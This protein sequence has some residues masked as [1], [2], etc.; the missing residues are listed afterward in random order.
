MAPN[1]EHNMKRPPVVVIVG[2][3]D[4]GKTTL[5]DYIRKTS[6]ATREAG[7]I[8]QSIGAYEI[9]HHSERI[10]FIDTP[11]HEA[12]SNMRRRGVAVADIAI[13][14]V[15]VDD[16]VQ[17]Q[18]REAIK[19]IRES[20]T[21]CI[22][23]FNKIDKSGVNVERVQ[24][25]LATEGIL[26]EGRGGNVSFQMISA[27]TGEGIPELL[28][29]IALVADVQG[30]TYDSSLPGE[31]VIIESKLDGKSGVTA[32]AVIKNGTL[33]VGD[34]ISAGKA[35]GKVRG[36]ENF[37]GERVTEVAPSTPV[38]VFGF[39]DLPGVGELLLSGSRANSSGAAAG[40]PKAI[41]PRLPANAPK[42]QGA[43]NIIL[44]ADVAGSLETLGEIMKKIKVP[45]N[46]KIKI[47]DS[48]VGDI[49]DGDAKLAVSTGSII[50]GFNVKITKAGANVAGAHRVAVITSDIIYDLEKKIMGQFIG[51]DASAV[52]GDLEILAV[53]GKKGVREQI[54]GGKIIAGSISNG[55]A[56]ELMRNGVSLGKGKITNLQT[57]KKNAVRVETG[58]EA[59][60]LVEADAEIKIGDHILSR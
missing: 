16:G 60:L 49:T 40:A 27:K 54:I 41:A 22:V 33:R 47:I 30:F 57:K 58:N 26:L 53:F 5:L 37:L 55:V 10:T 6:I 9:T 8:T 51:G 48:S 1:K 4:H 23:A 18:T 38:V 52:K 19:I 56:F 29:L 45:G 3:V 2:H 32:V 24:D 35:T 46:G 36:L 15:A 59:G 50:V 17:P 13:L 21:P 14:V 28:D 42:E 31:G 34:V 12:F 20:E 7:G 43:V 44:K 39:E 11:G 25:A